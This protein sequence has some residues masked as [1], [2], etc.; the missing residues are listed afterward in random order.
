[1][2]AASPAALAF[3]GV[4]KAYGAVTALDD[5]SFEVAQGE[6]F[7]MIG[8]DGAGKTTSIRLACGLTHADRGSVSVLGHDPVRSHRAITGDVGYLSQRFSLYGDL[9][10]D[11]NIGFFA[12]I[13]GV[14]R[15]QA[16]R[17]RLLDMTQL[18]PFRARRADRLSGG[19]KQKLALACTLVHEPKVLLLDE[20][21]TGVDPVSRREFWKLLSEFLASGLTVVMATPYLDE[22]ERCSR[23]VLLHEGRVLSVDRPERLQD[24]LR[25]HIL[26]VI[27]DTPRPPTDLLASVA[28]VADVQPFGERAHV[29]SAGADAT[30]TE[31]H[32]RAAL[33]RAGL[34]VV[35]VRPVAASLEDV[36]IELVG[37]REAG[38]NV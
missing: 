20:P 21:T 34:G 14:R 32:V 4:R 30:E 37:R 17:D 19:M 38:R 26:E 2:T 35:S 1:V 25:G 8:P 10:I 12:A 28:G 29:R 5:V 18:T 9:T 23:I 13:H 24:T 11:E 6:M 16:A 7:G 22:A 3:A 31:R 36:F 33:E 27:T 15:Y